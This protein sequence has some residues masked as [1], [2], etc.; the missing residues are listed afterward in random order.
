MNEKITEYQTDVLI[1][2]SGGSGLRCAIELCDQG[3]KDILVIGKCKL[4]EAHTKEAEGGINAALGNVDKEDNW[5]WHVKDTLSESGYLANGKQAELVCK[6]MIPDIQELQTMGVPFNQTKNGKIN[7]RQFGGQTFNRTCFVGDYTG[8]AILETLVKQVQKRKIK[9]LENIYVTQL[10]ASKGKISGIFGLD[11]ESG[12]F[13]Q[14]Q[15]KIVVLA[16]GGYTRVYK[17]A[18]SDQFVNTGDSIWLAL[19]AGLELKDMELVQF[20]PTGMVWPEEA[21]GKL[22]T[23]GVRSEGGYLTN[24]KGER[25]MQKYDSERMELSTRDRVAR[26]N[27]FEIR[28]GNTTPHG[29]VW[30]DIT[31]RTP[32]YIDERL[33][34][35]IQQFKQY[36]NV[37]I[38]TE[39]MEVAPTAHYSMGGIVIQ[40]ETGET[41]IKGLYAIGE[42][43]AGLHGGNRLGG[44]S[45]A[46]I[47]VWGKLAGKDIA[48]K[49][50]KFKQI[51]VNS[52]IVQNEI[53]RIQ[54]LFSGTKSN[55]VVLRTEL[56][57]LMWN[58]AGV[59]KNE[60]DLQKG[61][62][63][64]AILKE[65]TKNA[66]IKT[67]LKNNLELITVLDLEAQLATSECILKSALARKESRGAH[68]REDF[69]KTKKEWL[70]NL[71]CRQ[72]LKGKIKLTKKKVVKPSAE[73][74]KFLKKIK[75]KYGE[76]K[77]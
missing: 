25:F 42:A 41:K 66:K 75:E 19:N 48:K 40:P 52:K 10:L 59:V 51:K 22:I 50:K 45:L 27:F 12:Q 38:K 15:A 24:S 49:V 32:E 77:N 63:E 29:G 16:T 74:L 11:F 1:V 61:L 5:L 30:L 64:L 18:S 57:K 7:Q 70:V 8:K 76:W 26:A 17:T 34:K 44:N 71:I 62:T 36:G 53:E 54:N 2:G 58:H 47:I 73:V 68:Y 60:K 55:P 69:L 37:D 39:K 56:Q 3:I 20:H 21:Q 31:H 13:V 72:D 67:G 4:G 65:L 43:T 14:I 35:M 9:N 33:P 23:E 28:T 46:E 6:N